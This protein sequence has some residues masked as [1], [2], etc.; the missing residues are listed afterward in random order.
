VTLLVAVSS[1]LAA[2]TM[3]PQPGLTRVSIPVQ[4][5]L[6]R[7]PVSGPVPAPV[8]PSRPTGESTTLGA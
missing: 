5:P 3:V 6:V 1:L 2:P 7:S 8:H 4:Q